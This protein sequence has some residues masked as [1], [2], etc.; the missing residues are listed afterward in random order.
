MYGGQKKREGNGRGGESERN[1]NERLD[2]IR[3]AKVSWKI[4]YTF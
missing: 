4:Q 3:N 2:S 1:K